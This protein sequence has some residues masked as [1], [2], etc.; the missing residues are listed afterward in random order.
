MQEARAR[1][2]GVLGTTLARVAPPI[3]KS[4]AN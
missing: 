3:E 1:E 4:Q 2:P